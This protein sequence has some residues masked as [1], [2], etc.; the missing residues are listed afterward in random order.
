VSAKSLLLS[1]KKKLPRL[2]YSFVTWISHFAVLLISSTIIMI[3]LNRSYGQ[4]T[5]S[6][7]TSLNAELTNYV[8]KTSSQIQNMIKYNGFYTFYTPSVKKLRHPNE[9]TNFEVMSGIRDLNALVSTSTYIH[10]VYVYSAGNQYIYTTDELGSNTLDDFHDKSA[11]EIFR[12]GVSQEDSFEPLYRPLLYKNENNIEYI[13]SFILY[14]SNNEKDYDNA[15]M[16]N[17]YENEYNNSFFSSN[18]DKEIILV[19]DTGQVILHSKIEPTASE[20]INQLVMKEI[21]ESGKNS[22][23]I[24]D[25]Q[26]KDKPIY[27]YSYMNQTGRYLIRHLKYADVMNNLTS[28]KRLSLSIVLTI[29]VSG[30]IVSLIMLTRMYLPLKK[31]IFSLSGQAKAD[32]GSDAILKNLDYWV[33]DRVQDKHEYAALVKQE[34]LNQVLTSPVSPIE[35]TEQN[36]LQYGIDLVPDMPLYLLL[37]VDISPREGVEA[38]KKAFPLTHM[39]GISVDEQTIFF[40]QPDQ[41]T[42]I[43]SICHFLLGSG[44]RICIHSN[45]IFDFQRIERSYLRLKELYSLRIFHPHV[46]ILSD[47]FLDSQNK[48]NIYP[49]QQE[50]KIVLALRSGKYENAI[51]LYRDWMKI[52]SQHRYS[53]I[54]FALKR[55]YLTIKPLHQLVISSSSKPVMQADLDFIE[56]KLRVIEDI[57]E[58]NQMFYSLFSQ[59]CDKVSQDKTEKIEKVIQ[60]IKSI[61]EENYADPNLSPQ[62]I[63]D[64]INLSATYIGKLFRSCEKC[65]ISDYINKIRI[66]HAQ[67]LLLNKDMTVKEVAQKAGFVNISYFFTLFK[68]YCNMSPASYRKKRLS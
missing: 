61:V 20:G 34:L 64:S 66:D 54:V 59:I 12:G 14:E 55:L 42:G 47:H 56:D 62:S 53:I 33:Q 16:I 39:E 4:A 7:I 3:M 48:K 21:L 65:S 11:A 31:I 67:K 60:E 57:E 49:E 46:N 28:I 10:S 43:D 6:T 29:V 25:E 8:E 50:S 35:N 32:K 37:V 30:C 22:G 44:V 51:A 58:F 52:I 24:I 45:P 9:L 63:S 26:H 23:H 1:V 5:I 38:I 2:P 27:L 41:Q 40:I 19:K 17:V 13:Y 15:L 36:F 68:N 18:Y